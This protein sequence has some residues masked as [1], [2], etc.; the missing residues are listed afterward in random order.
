MRIESGTSSYN[1]DYF[2]IEESSS[3]SVD[4][5]VEAESYDE[6][7]YFDTNTVNLGGSPLRNDGVDIRE[8]DGY[9]FIGWIYAGEYLEYT[10][11]VIDSG[12]YDFIFSLASLEAT[13]KSLHLEIDGAISEALNYNT[14]GAGWQSYQDFILPSIDLNSGVQTIRVVFDSPSVNFEQFTIKTA[15]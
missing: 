14:G 3:P 10:I 7:G 4:T 11:E 2:S 13:D 9:H 6:G 12:F 5:I 8:K 15:E 1:F